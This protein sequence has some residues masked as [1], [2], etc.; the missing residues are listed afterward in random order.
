MLV[1]IAKRL[2]NMVATMVTVSILVFLLLEFSPGSVAIKVLGPYSSEEQRQIW[3]ENNG[4]NRPIYTRYA[5]WLGRFV[6]GD[7]GE[8]TRFK[9]PVNDILWSRLSTSFNN[10]L[11]ICPLI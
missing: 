11:E 4:Y 6:T 9:Q 2:A 1:L 8:S 5:D 7:L 3:L 10:F